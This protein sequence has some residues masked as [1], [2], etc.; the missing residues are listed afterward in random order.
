MISAPRHVIQ[1]S[2]RVPGAVIYQLSRGGNYIYQVICWYPTFFLHYLPVPVGWQQYL[3]R[4]PS[5]KNNTKKKSARGY[6]IRTSQTVPGAAIYEIFGEWGTINICHTF[7]SYFFLSFNPLISRYVNS[8]IFFV[9]LRTTT[10]TAATTTT[11][12]ALGARY[13]NMVRGTS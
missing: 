6:A 12:K 4:V 2:Q 13:E 7:I 1:T 3:L 5:N 11:T 8:S 9:F 10:A